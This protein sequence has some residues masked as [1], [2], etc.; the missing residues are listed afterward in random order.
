MQAR[1]MMGTVVRKPGQVAR[2]GPFFPSL[3]LFAAV[4]VSRGRAFYEDEPANPARPA[5]TILT[6]AEE[7]LKG[8]VTFLAA[9]ARD[10]RA[11][12]TKGIEAAADYIADVFK[13]AGL[14]PAPGPTATFSRSRS[15]AV[16]RSGPSKNWR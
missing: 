15:A 13:E 5:A 12:G 7:R 4:L 11:P 1:S 9:D 14:K 6:A 10:G 3:A 16:P 2:C 8:D